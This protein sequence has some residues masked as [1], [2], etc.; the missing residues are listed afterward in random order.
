MLTAAARPFTP[1]FVPWCTLS[2]TGP[3][4]GARWVITFVTTDNE[5]S[6]KGCHRAGFCP[7][8]LR[9]ERWLLFRRRLSFEPLLPGPAQETR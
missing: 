3:H 1:V 2:F 4:L 9:R 6:L 8:V 7:Y 5:P